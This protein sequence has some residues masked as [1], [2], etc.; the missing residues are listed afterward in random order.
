MAAPTAPAT[1]SYPDFPTFVS[2]L[3][4]A[5]AGFRRG[6]KDYLTYITSSHPDDELDM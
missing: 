1:G 6:G 4:A 3:L 2:T 5:L